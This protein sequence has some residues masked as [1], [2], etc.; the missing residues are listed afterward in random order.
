MFTP[1]DVRKAFANGVF[2]RPA[3][4]AVIAQVEQ[5]LGHGLPDQLRSL[6]LA[7]D[8]FQ[9]PTGANFLFPVLEQATKGS[10][11]LLTCTQFFRNEDYF[12]EWLQHAIPVGDN[13][14]GATWFTL[15]EEGERLVR[16]D[17][18]WEEY[19]EVEGTLLDAWIAER[20]LYESISPRI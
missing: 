4:A 5:A 19:E 7:F 12:P 16:W 11:S 8:G 2:R 6:Y 17:A 14:T 18:E 20:K 13:G 15:L 3:I 9:G 1:E 10:E